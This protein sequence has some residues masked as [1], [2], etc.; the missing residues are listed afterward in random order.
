MGMWALSGAHAG[1]GGCICGSGMEC[2]CK[3][4][5]VSTGKPSV[6][7]PESHYTSAHFTLSG[8]VFTVHFNTK[9]PK[10]KSNAIN[11]R[12]PVALDPD[13]CK[14]FGYT[15]MVVVPGKYSLK[16]DLLAL[17]VKLGKKLVKAKGDTLPK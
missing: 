14:E 3:I 2:I 17:N 13:T 15:S 7:Y 9:I 8:T 6:L 4:V 10:L 1:D 11:Q 5:N 16:S 12:E